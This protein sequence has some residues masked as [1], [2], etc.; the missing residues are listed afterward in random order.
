VL[1]VS[2]KTDQTIRIE[3]PAHIRIL[4]TSKGKVS[5]GIEAN[6]N[7]RILRGELLERGQQGP[8]TGETCLRCNGQGT[9]G[10]DLL[11]EVEPCE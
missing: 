11:K 10:M 6:R 8:C 1:V 2:R 3:G 7:V 5:I 9:C 4:K